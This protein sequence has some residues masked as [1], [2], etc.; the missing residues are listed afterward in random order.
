MQYKA[1]YFL[2]SIFDLFQ[3]QSVKEKVEKIVFQLCH[4]NLETNDDLTHQQV[5]YSAE[6]KTIHNMEA[7]IESVSEMETNHII[8]A[9]EENLP[10]YLLN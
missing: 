3:N 7:F 5:N 2:N 9:T 10:V 4:F 1:G 8:H 6:I